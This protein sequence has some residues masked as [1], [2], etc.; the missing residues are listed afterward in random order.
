MESITVFGVSI[1]GQ[2]GF[3]LEYFLK[4]A[5]CLCRLST[6]VPHI[7]EGG[8]LEIQTFKLKKCIT[9]AKQFILTLNRHFWQYAVM[10]RFLHKS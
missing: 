6:N 9:E 2:Q 8:E 10:C 7:A 4:T 1:R 5:E 3:L